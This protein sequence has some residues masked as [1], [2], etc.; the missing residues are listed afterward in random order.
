MSDIFEMSTLEEVQ[1]ELGGDS[2]MNMYWT[3]CIKTLEVA[4]DTAAVQLYDYIEADKND[5]AISLPEMIDAHTDI[6]T[7]IGGVY[8]CGRGFRPLSTWVLREFGRDCEKESGISSIMCG[9]YIG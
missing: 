7:D 3:K 5:P 6:R 4:L 1:D 8:S 2:D 9:R